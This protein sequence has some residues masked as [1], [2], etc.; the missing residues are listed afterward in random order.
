MFAVSCKVRAAVMLQHCT[1][2][3]PLPADCSRAQLPCMKLVSQDLPL[4]EDG[5]NGNRSP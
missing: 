4:M 2:G 5:L 1:A 3:L